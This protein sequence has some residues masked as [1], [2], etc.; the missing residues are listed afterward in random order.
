MAEHPLVVPQYLQAEDNFE[1]GLSTMCFVVSP[2]GLG[3]VHIKV[4]Y[5]DQVSGKNGYIAKTSDYPD[6]AWV[7]AEI[8]GHRRYIFSIY[9]QN[10][11]SDTDDDYAEVY[12]LRLH[13]VRT[14]M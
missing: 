13:Q 4:M 7:W 1:P 12:I 6:G 11:Q 9:N 10:D 5:L 8:D 14:E 3:C 2:K